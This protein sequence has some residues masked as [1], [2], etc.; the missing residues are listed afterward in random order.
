MAVSV[1]ALT[2]C[3]AQPA[4]STPPSVSS[5]ASASP[6]ASAAPTVK[7]VL[8]PT[9]TASDNLAYFNLVNSTFLAPNPMPGGRAII[10]NLVAAGFQKSLMQLTPDRTTIG[11][12]VDSV[13]FSVRFGTTCLVGSVNTSGYVGV[14]GPAVSGS[15]CL[16]G[17]TRAIDW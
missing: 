8:D 10:D 1:V 14:A 6:G 15:L 2:G 5:S 3:T 11:R 13:Q 17:V 16:L 4:P 12:D 7:P 9:G